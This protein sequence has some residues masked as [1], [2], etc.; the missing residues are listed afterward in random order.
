MDETDDGSHSMR[1]WEVLLE[2]KKV[3][4]EFQHLEDLVFTEPKNG[5]KKAVEILRSLEQGA[6][7]VAIK[8]DGNP[9]IFWGRDEAGT[10]RLVGKNNWGRDEGKSDSPRDLEQ[11]ILSRGKGEDWREKFAGDMANLWPLFEKATPENF[12]GYVFGD[13]LYHP[14]KPYEGGNGKISFTPNVT[15]YHVDATSKLGTRIAKSKV[16]VAATLKFDEWGAPMNAGTPFDNVED[17]RINPEVVV[18]GQ[19]YIDHR[20]AVDVENLDSIAKTADQYQDKIAKFLEPFRGLS[21]LQNII[22]SF[23]NNQSK[24][25]NLQGIDTEGFYAF[26]QQKVSEPKQARIKQLDENNPG[27]L[28]SILIL[29][30]ELMQ[31]KDEVIDEL[32]S[33]EADITATTGDETGGEGYVK[34]RDKVKLVP[35]SRWKPA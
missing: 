26:V 29:V 27:V 12:R 10:F 35:R 18:L 2:A 8:W 6:K 22:Y 30:Q 7:D 11:F 13:L 24:Q 28:D 32:D 23:V 4:R 17:F 33:A 1:F 19:T 21:D 15:T 5:A 34:Q 31:A 3:G 14:G 25:N 9:T 20:P 16:G